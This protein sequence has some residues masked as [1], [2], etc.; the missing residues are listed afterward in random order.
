MDCRGGRKGE[1]FNYAKHTEGRATFEA[2]GAGAPLSIRAVSPRYDLAQ[3][4]TSG[5]H[6]AHGNPRPLLE[7]I[8]D[9]WVLHSIERTCVAGLYRTTFGIELRLHLGDEQVESRLS[10]YRE[11]PLLL[12][13]EEAKQD[14]LNQGWTELPLNATASRETHWSAAPR[15]YTEGSHCGVYRD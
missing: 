4:L 6:R 9:V 11:T 15:D 13:A 1:T 12:I 8:R 3:C 2:S 5:R 7:H 10:R 14:L